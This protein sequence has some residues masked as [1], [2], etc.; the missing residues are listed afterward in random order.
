M[1][2]GSVDL[3]LTN[4]LDNAV[5]FSPPGVRV[6]VRLAVTENEAA[7]SVFDNG[8]GIEQ[9]EQ[10]RIFERFY[11]GSI[12]S[13]AHVAG[14]GLGLALSQAIACGHGGY[15]EMTNNDEGGSVFIFKFPLAR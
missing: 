5:K 1:A 2:Y 11:R 8:P 10:K 9:D 12:T 14:A 4:L 13:T 6:F 7:L 15:I 3:I